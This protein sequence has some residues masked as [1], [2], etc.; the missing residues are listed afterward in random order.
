MNTEA[1]SQDLVEL[2]HF[3]VQS[4]LNDRPKSFPGT[5]APGSWRPDEGTVEVDYTHTAAL[6]TT[7]TEEPLKHARLPLATTSYGRQAGPLGGEACT[8]IPIGSGRNLVLLDHDLGESPQAPAG[9]DHYVHRNVTTGAFDAYTHHTNDGATAG[10]GLAGKR[11]LV[12]GY[13]QRATTAG[14]SDTL[15]DTAKKMTRQSAGGHV[16]IFDDAGHVISRATSGGLIAKM[17]D[18]AK[19][20]SHIAV[21]AQTVVDGTIDA[22]THSAG[23]GTVKTIVDGAG[24]AISHIVPGGGLVGLGALASSLPAARALITNADMT[25]FEQDMWT[26]NRDHLLKFATAMIAAGVPNASGVMA[27]LAAL[28]HVPVP[29]GSS[30]VR[31]AA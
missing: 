22:V 2:I 12:G 3:V 10:D 26:K 21:S 13:A 8:V 25:Q 14:H 16:D 20:I 19:A 4:V 6:A 30:V 7:A 5:I 18:A 11:E 1:V 29:G 24:N 28:L 27:L 17:D 23:G 9:E 15:D 31:A